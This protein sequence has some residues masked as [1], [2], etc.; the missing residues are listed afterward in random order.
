LDLAGLAATLDANLSGLAGTPRFDVALNANH[1]EL[2]QLASAFGMPGS[3]LRGRG[4]LAAKVRGS[5]EAIDIDTKVEAAGANFTAG[6]RIAD[7][8]GRGTADLTLALLHPDFAQFMRVLDPQYQSAEARPGALD[9]KAVIKGD[10]QAYNVSGLRLAVG[11]MAINGDAT[12]ALAGPRPKLTASLDGGHLD[13][14]RLLP[15]AKAPVRPAAATSAAAPGPGGGGASSGSPFTREPIDFSALGDA[16]ADVKFA[17]RSVT[18]RNFR[19][20]E[21]RVAL[22]L[23]DRVL[24]LNE[25]IGRMFD[26]GIDAKAEIDGRATPK[27]QAT[28]KIDRANVGKALFETA[29]VDLAKG[30]LAF[31]MSVAGTGKSSQDIASS[32]NGAAK[33]SVVNGSIKGFNLRAASDRLKNIDRP[34]DLLGLLQPAMGGGETQFSSL[35]GTFNIDNGVVRTDDTKL[36]ADAGAGDVKGAVD[37]GRWHMDMLGWFRLTEH[38]NAPPFGMRMVGPPDNAQRIFDTNDLQ[39]FLVSR[40]VGTLLK[41]VLPQ[42]PLQQQQAPTAAQPSQQQQQQQ[43]QKPKPEDILKGL[44]QGLGRPRQ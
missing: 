30:T 39:R 2:A 14:N 29:D 24:K 4:H 18:Y 23:A 32:L 3:P 33:L 22:T 6:G 9:V 5:L 25:M 31:D 13:V 15:P 12:L 21:P 35:A 42:Q 27:V 19:V 34:A 26:G 16:D 28:I 7:P 17:S 11:P 1:S 38:P 36:I 40:G 8:A 44:L 20:E 10:K 37:L 43:Q 41:K